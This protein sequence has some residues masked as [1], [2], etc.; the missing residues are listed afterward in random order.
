MDPGRTLHSARRKR[1]RAKTLVEVPYSILEQEYQLELSGK[2][3][4]AEAQQAAAT[5]IG[6]M[7]YEGANYFWINDDHPTM[8]MHPIKPDMDGTDL[9]SF[10]DPAGTA[11]F[12]EFVKAARSRG[13]GFVY[14][15][16][17]KPGR[18]EPVQK[19][20]YVKRF[21]P[22]GWIVGTGIYID[23]VNAAWKQSA[24]KA[25]SIAFACLIPLIVLMAVLTRSVFVRI[26]DMVHRYQEIAEGDGDVTK[27]IPVAHDEIG[28]L[29][30]WF[31]TVLDKLQH[32]ISSVA[33]ATRRL[34]NA[35]K[36]A[37][38]GSEQIF[39][40]S[41]ETSA[42]AAAISS[43]AGQVTAN[44]QTAT[45]GAEQMGASIKE[46]ARN[47]TEAA[48]VANSAVEIAT[49][50]NSTVAKL[51]DSSGEIGQVIRVITSIAM[52]TNLLALNATIEA[53]RAGEA[54]KGFAVVADEVKELAKETAKATEDISHRIEAIQTDT[55]G[56]VAAI[57]SISGVI[58][59]INGI[60]STIARAVEA[61]NITTQEMTWN[62]NEAS[63]C[64]G[65]ITSNIT[66]MSR[67]A[68]STSKGASSTQDL[69]RQLV[70]MSVELHALVGRFKVGGD[71]SFDDNSSD[72]EQHLAGAA[73]AG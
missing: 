55:R 34:E 64:G 41:L 66:G 44:L 27:R 51:G 46:I 50:A 15:L 70:E 14:Y 58:N 47:A 29:A 7:R 35:S 25:I 57:A 63:R 65:E 62:I 17:P 10:H 6:S 5:I 20:S 31:N 38:K 9:T 73:H 67:S 33:D 56:A 26:A 16:W 1:Q 28:D 24:W 36:D 39:S 49:T 37:Y 23:E 3:T 40:S 52:Q 45:T 32:M 53:A 30:K 21:G 8:I 60:S 22:W 68:D 59:Q 11:V 4:E 19:L 48:D 12:V 43:A 2:L 42:Q 71:Q 13:G 72:P 61:Q 54:G 69:A 18:T